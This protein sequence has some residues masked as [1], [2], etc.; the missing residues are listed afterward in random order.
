[1][2]HPQRQGRSTV[3]VCLDHLSKQQGTHSVIHST[4]H[5]ILTIRTGA[6]TL[7][8]TG[9]E[10]QNVP[11]TMQRVLAANMAILLQTSKVIHNHLP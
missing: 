2:H 5:S 8:A 1:M 9:M 10:L 11:I 3:A 6:N 4:N 7:N